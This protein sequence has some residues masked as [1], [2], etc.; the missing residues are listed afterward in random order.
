MHLIARRPFP[1]YV[2]PAYFRLVIAARGHEILQMTFKQPAVISSSRNASNLRPR[3]PS[4]VGRI[5]H[6]PTRPRVI[7]IGWRE[8]KPQDIHNGQIFYERSIRF[9]LSNRRRLFEL[10]WHNDVGSFGARYV[11]KKEE[12]QYASRKKWVVACNLP[13]IWQP[14]RVV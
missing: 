3:K 13:I 7:A 11:K 12:R 1:L 8:R 4:K 2:Y 14:T 9:C 10:I 6:W 5:V